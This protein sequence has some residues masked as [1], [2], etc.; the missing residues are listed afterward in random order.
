MS[1][2]GSLNACHVVPVHNPLGKLVRSS[3]FHSSDSLKKNYRSCRACITEKPSNISVENGSGRA[4]KCTYGDHNSQWLSLELQHLLSMQTDKPS[5]GIVLTRGKW[6][7][8]LQEGSLYR[9]CG[10]MSF[11][12]VT[13]RNEVFIT[14]VQGRL[15]LFS[16]ECLDGIATS[17]Q[18]ISRHPGGKPAPRND[19]YWPVFIIRAGEDTSM[20]VVIQ[21]MAEGEK[22]LKDLQAVRV[23][24]EYVAYGP[25]GRSTHLQ[26]VILPLQYTLSSHGTLSWKK[27]GGT[28][29]VL[30]VRTHLLCHLDD[31]VQVLKSYILPHAKAGDVITIGE[32]PFAIMQ[33]RFRHPHGIHPSILACLLCRLFHPTSS[34]ATACGMQAL[35]DICGKL[36]VVFAAFLAVI[37][38]LLG[39]RGMFYCLAG[40]QARLIDDASGTLPPY[41]QFVTL[42]PV[43][44]QEI[45]NTLK[46]KTGYEVAVVDAND[47]KRVQI[48]AASSGVD[49]QRLEMVLI[50]N[51]AGNADEQTPIVLV[52][53]LGAPVN[54]ACG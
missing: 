31:P 32:T 47:L 44:A 51:P 48:L 29:S 38:R 49:H 23:E 35:I 15:R 20:E 8:V 39:I 43:C 24:L 9:L 52:R 18:I 10:I 12:N 13:K 21:V 45:V 33:G 1:C 6:R 4:V 16:T 34:L 37:A 54:A 41:D 25:H 2:L 17:I 14:E 11:H 3:K 27:V 30:P 28:C 26:H 19:G 7:W 42:G 40:E 5:S 50:D 36:R 53:G 46:L 22:T